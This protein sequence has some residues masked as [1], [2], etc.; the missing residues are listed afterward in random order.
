MFEFFFR[1][2]FLF[3]DSTFDVGVQVKHITGLIQRPDVSGHGGSS[4]MVVANGHRRWVVA[5]GHCES[6]PM[7]PTSTPHLISSRSDCSYQLFAFRR[8]TGPNSRTHSWHQ[9]FFNIFHLLCMNVFECVNAYNLIIQT[10]EQVFYRPVWRQILW[11]GGSRYRNKIHLAA[12]VTVSR[13]R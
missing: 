11:I 12:I 7:S 6:S 3:R 13:Y 5:S 10:N 8:I 9:V 2:E 4:P 1:T